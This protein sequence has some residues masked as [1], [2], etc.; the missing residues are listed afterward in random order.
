M[1]T[2]TNYVNDEGPLLPEHT[3][4]AAKAFA[5]L[6]FYSVLM[7]SLP[8]GAFFATRYILRDTY[9]VE[10]FAN[11]AWSVLAAVVTVNLIICAYAYQ[12]YHDQEYDDEGNEIVEE[13]SQLNLK[14]D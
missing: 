6:L 7:F 4:Q 3:K 13:K 8:F 1:E 10:G 5:L 2:D 9:N 12:A 11:T 14:Q